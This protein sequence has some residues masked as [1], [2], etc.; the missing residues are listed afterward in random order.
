M[1]DVKKQLKK[2]L[3][4]ITA[5]EID[6]L[7]TGKSLDANQ[8]EHLVE[9]VDGILTDIDKKHNE[10]QAK[11]DKETGFVQKGKLKLEMVKINRLHT[12]VKIFADKLRHVAAR[13]KPRTKTLTETGNLALVKDF[14]GLETKRWDSYYDEDDG[15]DKEKKACIAAMHE[16]ADGIECKIKKITKTHEKGLSKIQSIMKKKLGEAARS[17]STGRSSGRPRG[18]RPR[19]ARQLRPKKNSHWEMPQRNPKFVEDFDSDGNSTY[20]A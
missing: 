11:L 8:Y 16:R 14:S 2:V 20:W 6:L 7:L 4:G 1:L 12:K 10:F 13:H 19:P 15:D 18:S 9:S 17:R 5:L 3:D